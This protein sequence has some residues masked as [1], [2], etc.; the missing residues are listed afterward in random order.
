MTDKK[1]LSRQEWR[2]H[3]PLL[4]AATF[5]ISF[6]GIPTTTLGLFMQPLQDAFG[7]SRTT[8][9]LG[10]TVFA[11]A[12]IP[13]SPVAGAMVDRFGARAIAI[14]GL[15][16]CGLSFAGF[17]LMNGAIAL[18]IGMWV[19]YSSV[20]VL[21]RTMV[22]NPPVATAF[23]INRGIALAIM[24][25]GM[26]VASATVPLLTHTLIS[27][28]GW[29]TAYIALGLGWTGI[30]LL[31]VI[32]FFKVTPRAQLPRAEASSE[33]AEALE[34]ASVPGG[35]TFGQALRSVTIIRIALAC[36][37][38]TLLGSAWGVH[39]IPIYTSLGVERVTAASLAMVSGAAA[40]ASRLVAGSILDRFNFGMLPLVFLAT[41]AIAY[42]LLLV[43]HGSLPIIVAVAL[44]IGIGSGASLY[45]IIYLTTQYAGLRH[46]GK[47]Y[48][49]ISMMTGISAGI[50]PVSAG[51]IYDTTGSYE[52]YL[53][54][55]I[56][57]FILSGLLVMGLG[58]YPEFAP[59]D[60]PAT[61]Q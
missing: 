44:L 61:S 54:I 22:W 34:A 47:I 58:P 19:I 50:G 23:V 4:L 49:T 3:W 57:I 42:A 33:T 32:P 25:S 38:A 60:A 31:L 24:L 52:L 51:W 10:M 6:G 18:W 26:S 29:R 8:I 13:L 30:A 20:S 15:A 55:G 7:W 43:G 48:G 2:L 45:L 9:S 59:D 36:L 28:F 16:L 1:A 41:P 17:S 53:M 46:F 39:M 12:V 35:L 14:P 11:V 27:E 5:G 37:L 40:I 21:I 56:P